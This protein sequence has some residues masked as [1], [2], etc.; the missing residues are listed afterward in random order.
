MPAS[1][2]SSTSS[3]EEWDSFIVV[4]LSRKGEDEIVRFL[5]V[6]VSNLSCG[7]T[8]MHSVTDGFGPPFYTNWG[9]VIEGT[10]YKM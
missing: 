2:T 7:G 9:F 8:F 3:E 10:F 1:S 5:Q 4:D 6:I